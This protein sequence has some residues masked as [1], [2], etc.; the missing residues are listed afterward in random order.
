M[1]R[2]LAVLSFVLALP[3]MARAERTIANDTVTAETP[4]SVLC[5]FCT[6]ERFGSVFVPERS[7]YPFDLVDV[8]I[9]IA[10]A[11]RTGARCEA[12]MDPG[13]VRTSR[14]EIWVGDAAEPALDPGG[15]GERLVWTFEEAPLVASAAETG[16]AD[17]AVT[18]TT[19]PVEATERIESAGYVRV[20]VDI[21]PP[22]VPMP[23]SCSSAMTGEDPDAF[24]IGDR[25]G[26][27]PHRNLVYSTSGAGSWHWSEDLGIEGDWAVRLTIQTRTSGRDAGPSI[28]AGS[29]DAGAAE[30]GAGDGASTD[31]GDGA[32]R[33]AGAGSADGAAAMDAASQP[34]DT[35][36]EG[37]G[38][39]AAG[40][41]RTSDRDEVETTRSI[42]RWSWLVLLMGVVAMRGRRRR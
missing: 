23:G 17:I 11:R 35:A 7:D 19:L 24:P 13:D 34:L 41:A 42:A 4:A 25:D 2:W 26:I 20:L 22:V 10:A 12:S 5:G 27:M 32:T 3:S 16:V 6:G 21:S 15:D 37:C 29:R 28:D 1:A 31:A 36:D 40:R 39:V 8:R 30:G 18:F 9:A 38:C 33:D 14:I